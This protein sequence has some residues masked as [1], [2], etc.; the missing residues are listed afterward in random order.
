[1][2]LE[3]LNRL[4][5]EPKVAAKPASNF[6]AGE[7]SRLLNEEAIEISQSKFKPLHLAEIIKLTQDGAVSSTG[8][9]TLISTVW[10][11]GEAVQTI[12]D[13]EG[14]RQVSDT[15]ALEPAIDAVIGENSAQVAEFRAGKDKLLGF[16]VGQVMKKTGGKANPAL[17]QELIR[18]K[19][20][21]G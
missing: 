14:L 6:L 17:L 8:A 1:L 4:G 13:R 20:A 21:S 12:V 9:K 5:L 3:N 7:V 10:K 11:T 2:T 16:F 15:S 19:L 18:R